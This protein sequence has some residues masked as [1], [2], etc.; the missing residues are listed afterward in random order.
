MNF[1]EPE[2]DLREASRRFDA[3]RVRAEEFDGK[4]LRLMVQD[5]EGPRWGKGRKAVGRCAG[6]EGG[7][8]RR[9]SQGYRSP[10]AEDRADHCSQL[11]MT[12]SFL[13]ESRVRDERSPFS[14]PKQNEQVTPQAIIGSPLT[15]RR[16]G[17]GADSAAPI[18]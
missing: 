4:R 10:V 17:D 14:R 11:D 15:R 5:D 12:A 3:G 1:E 9:T 7:W 16:S 18:Q 2:V 13:S 8:V 6:I